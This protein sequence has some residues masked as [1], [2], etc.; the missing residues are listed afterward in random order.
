M[1]RATGMENALV[2]RTP[3]IEIETAIATRRAG[4]AA[5]NLIHLMLTG[6]L[7]YSD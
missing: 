2:G 4:Y 6:L 7:L 1:Q 5:A 3:P